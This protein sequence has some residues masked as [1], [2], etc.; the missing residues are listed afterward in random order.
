[1]R[2]IYTFIVG[3]L[4]GVLTTLVCMTLIS[5]WVEA[6]TFN[7]IFNNVEQGPNSTASPS[8]SVSGEKPKLVQS[9]PEEGGAPVESLPSPVPSVAPVFPATQ[10]TVTH[11]S[12]PGH[13][14]DKRKA[15]RAELLAHSVNRDQGVGGTFT[16]GYFPLRELGVSARFGTGADFKQSAYW[17]GELEVIPLRLS[18]FGAQDM[19]DLGAVVGGSSL[20]HALGTATAHA[21]VKSSIHFGDRFALTAGLR[22]NLTSRSEFTYLLADAG[23]SLRF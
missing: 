4:A 15:W 1:M 7:Y 22:T 9:P 19:L 11:A 20:G 23:I 14:A 6:A 18:V 16:L 8:L 2:F 5:S 21:G 3:L 12:S 17:G 13:D 10:S